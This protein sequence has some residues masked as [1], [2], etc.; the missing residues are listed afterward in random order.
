MG[1]TEEAASLFREGRNPAEIAKTLG[2]S[3]NSVFGYLNRAVGEG[4][5]RRSD[6]YF[7]FP[8]KL[9]AKYAAVLRQYADARVALGDMYEDIRRI[10]TTLHGHIQKTL[11]GT[12]GEDESGWWRQGVPQ[13]VRVKCQERREKDLDEPCDPYCYTDLLDLAQIVESN[14]PL[15]KDQF[16]DKY[17]TNRKALLDHLA[18]L[19]RVRNKVMHPVRG[20]APSEDDFDFVRQFERDLN[21]TEHRAVDG[22]PKD[23]WL[24][25]FEAN[26]E[27]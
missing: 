25:I 19:N 14:W 6:I 13:A 16:S 5:L 9:R 24:Q 2:L 11:I 15:F 20:L 3:L 22:V 4:Y 17:S 18:R 1:R 7:S 8:P 26:P 10:E 23:Q 12:Y 21:L 27:E